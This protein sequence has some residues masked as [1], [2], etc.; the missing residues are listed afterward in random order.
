[1][2]NLNPE[3]FS[4]IRMK[5]LTQI[6]GMS[7]ARF[8]QKLRHHKIKGQEQSFT[9][10]ELEKLKKGLTTLMDILNAE[11]GKAIS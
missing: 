8:T 2:E 9:S 6:M 11:V 4:F 7:Q 3:I 10:E 5:P 1:M